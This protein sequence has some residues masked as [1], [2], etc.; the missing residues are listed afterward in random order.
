MQCRMGIAC[1]VNFFLVKCAALLCWFKGEEMFHG[2]V[3][4]VFAEYVVANGGWTWGETDYVTC[5]PHVCSGWLAFHAEAN[6]ERPVL[7][8]RRLYCD[9]DTVVVAAHT[10]GRIELLPEKNGLSGVSSS[11]QM[12]ILPRMVAI[13]VVRAQ[14]IAIPEYATFLDLMVKQPA[15][16]RPKLIWD[17]IDENGNVLE[18]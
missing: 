4:L 5:A 3:P 2:A 7:Y 13:A 18:F 12:G 9:P 11:A 17:W 16:T 8:A 14:S 15:L 1:Q 10:N 6:P